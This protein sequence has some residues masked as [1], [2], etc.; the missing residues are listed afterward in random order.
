MESEEEHARFIDRRVHFRGTARI[1]LDALRF[2]NKPGSHFI[3]P[4]NITRLVQI[5]ELEGCL[6]LDLEH[7]VP[8]IIS[9]DVFERS[10]RI[11]KITGGDL[12]EGQNPP[13]LRLPSYSS[14]RCLHGIHRIEAAHK[15]LLAGDRWWTV[16]LYSD[17]QYKTL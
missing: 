5:F 6:R 17:G 16:D 3:D 4:K 1:H 11:S 7:H 12:L 8:A 10:L 14:I 9:Q 13:E 15:F 2:D